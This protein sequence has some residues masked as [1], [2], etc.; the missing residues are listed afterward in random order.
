MKTEISAGGI[1]VR[2]VGG[3]WDVLILQDANDAWTFPKGKIEAGEE[4]EKAAQREI[5]EEV[6]LKALTMLTKLPLIRY[7]YQK[8]GLISKTVHYFV[9]ES[10]GNEPLI[11]QSEEG[12]H[13]AVW[14]PVDK[15][16]E[17]IGYPKTNKGL[18]VKTKR[19]L[20]KLRPRL[21]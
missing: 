7:M 14:I 20:W 6:G 16:T 9:F 2:S 12:I 10:K 15:A 11:N 3:I 18:L 21:T 5:Y 1:V 8:N 4:P 17:L 13:N 19:F